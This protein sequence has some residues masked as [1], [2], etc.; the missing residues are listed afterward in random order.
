M[1]TF[2]RTSPARNWRKLRNLNGQDYRFAPNEI[3]LKKIKARKIKI[4]FFAG[5]QWLATFKTPPDDRNALL[6]RC[7]RL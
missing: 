3:P 6:K 5:R 4:S 1:Q 7:H 2:F